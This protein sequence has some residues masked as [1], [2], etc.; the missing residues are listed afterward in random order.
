MFR[1]TPNIEDD[2]LVLK[3]EG[4]LAGD[5]VREL[6][7]CWREATTALEGR[8]VRVDLRGVCHV[9]EAG[10]ELMTLMYRAG[11]RFVATGCVM[12]ELVREIAHSSGDTS[13]VPLAGGHS[14]AKTTIH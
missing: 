7:A 14:A 13:P 5:W 3:L 1:I 11:A 10:R 12:P 4:C 6:D 8:S 9:D 2:E